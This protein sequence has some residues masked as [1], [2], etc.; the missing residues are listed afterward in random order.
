MHTVVL[1]EDGTLWSAGVNDD[2]ALGRETAIDDSGDPVAEKDATRFGQ[3]TLP[4]DAA[5]VKQL[6]CSDSGSFALTLDGSV[7]GWGTFRNEHG[8]FGFSESVK[9]Q[10]TP[11]RVYNPDRMNAPAAKMAAGANHVVCILKVSSESLSKQC[12]SACMLHR[13]VK[14][15]LGVTAIK[16]NSDASLCAIR[17]VLK[18]LAARCLRR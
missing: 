17:D 2:G 3:V 13:M 14:R 10:M 15:F 11:V 5:P 7:Y 4:K 16:D 8:V 1:L 12:V 18:S 9:C 6:A